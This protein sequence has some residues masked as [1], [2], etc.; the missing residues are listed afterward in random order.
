MEVL[1]DLL[2]AGRV[3]RRRPARRHGDEAVEEGGEDL[4]GHGPVARLVGVRGAVEVDDDGGGGRGVCQGVGEGGDGGAGA[5]AREEVGGGTGE[6]GVEG[7]G[8]CCGFAAVEGAA[9][10]D[11]QEAGAEAVVVVGGRGGGEGGGGVVVGFGLGVGVHV[12]DG[13]FGFVFGGGH[14][15]FGSSCCD[16]GLV[17]VGDSGEVAVFVVAMKCFNTQNVCCLGMACTR[18]CSTP[19]CISGRPCGDVIAPEGSGRRE[20]RPSPGIVTMP[21]RIDHDAD[22]DS[23]TRWGDGGPARTREE[24]YPWTAYILVL[25]LLHAFCAE[26]DVDILLSWFLLIF[27]CGFGVAGTSCDVFSRVLETPTPGD[28]FQYPPLSNSWPIQGQ[29]TMGGVFQHPST[30][31]GG[32]LGG[33]GW[34]CGGLT[35]ESQANSIQFAFNKAN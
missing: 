3:A 11:L 28:S 14:V 10:A 18:H 33:G 22:W 23:G 15:C 24:R 17:T 2:G 4:F 30:H 26:K 19:D 5:Q 13:G 7:R 34:G 32:P 9:L 20:G 25:V 6:G 16:Q 12:G 27:G 1:G 35:P 29:S 8:A 31:R 21:W